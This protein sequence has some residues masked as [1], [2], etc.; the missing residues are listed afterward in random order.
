M[1]VPIA[2]WQLNAFKN[3]GSWESLGQKVRS[4]TGACVKEEYKVYG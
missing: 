2:F 3:N 4:S 1:K